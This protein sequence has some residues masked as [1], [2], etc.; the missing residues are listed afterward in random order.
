MPGHLPGRGCAHDPGQGRPC[1]G[2]LDPSS[3]DRSGDANQHLQG[4]GRE[5]FERVGG[6]DDG[7]IAVDAKRVAVWGRSN[8]V[9]RWGAEERRCVQRRCG[10]VASM[11]RSRGRA[12]RP[13]R[14]V[15]RSGK[16]GPPSIR[17]ITEV[18]VAPRDE[19]PLA[20]GACNAIGILP[21]W[22]WRVQVPAPA[23]MAKVFFRGREGVRTP[24]LDENV[25]TVE[26]EN[27]RI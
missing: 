4:K 27:G 7:I 23:Q 21:R 11:A 1:H 16:N 5:T 26:E 6:Q 12:T 19:R 14:L 8:A 25:V 15:L 13:D 9:S 2:A 18:P 10:R 17:A 22:T 24:C 20:R 3:A